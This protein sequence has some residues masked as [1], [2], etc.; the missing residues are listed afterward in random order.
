MTSIP[1]LA[2]DI[3]SLYE[4]SVAAPTASPM[5]PEDFGRALQDS[6]NNLNRLQQERNQ[7]IEDLVTGR[8]RD[9]HQ[10]MILME[11]SSV[12]T[13]LALQIRNKVIETYNEI[14]K[15]SV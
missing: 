8:N 14:M 4:H 15:M 11:K 1:P 6:F 12:S 3:R 7:S 5:R 2:T 9:L 10:T 13:Q